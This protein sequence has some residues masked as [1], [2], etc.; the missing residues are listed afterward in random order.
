MAVGIEG[1]GLGETETDRQ[2]QTETDRQTD[3]D[4][5]RDRQTDRHGKCVCRRGR[6][7]RRVRLSRSSNYA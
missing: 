6:E 5:D 2:R 4:R 7:G 3:M 1:R